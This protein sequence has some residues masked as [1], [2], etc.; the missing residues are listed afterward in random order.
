MQKLEAKSK[1][2]CDRRV[3]V[4]LSELV[5]IE[6]VL[7]QKYKHQL[8]EIYIADENLPL[9]A[10][11][12]VLLYLGNLVLFLLGT[13]RQLSISPLSQTFALGRMMMVIEKVYHIDEEH[14]ELI[15]LQFVF[16]FL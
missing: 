9:D 10:Y 4:L 3:L 7:F 2:S 1:C 8:M 13:Y 12:C 11:I 5:H 16:L 15:K 6:K 14:T